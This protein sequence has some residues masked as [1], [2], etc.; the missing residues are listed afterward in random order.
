MYAKTVI[1]LA[2]MLA[3]LSLAVTGCGTST[4]SKF[5]L[6]NSV[7]GPVKDSH[8][9]EKKSTVT[10]GVGPVEFPAYLDRQQIVTRI[11]ENEVDLAMF[12]EW[13]EPLKENFIRVLVENLA[14]LDTGDLFAVY[15]MRGSSPVDFQLEIEVLRLDGSLGGEVLLIARWTVFGGGTNQMLLTRKSTIKEASG[16]ADYRSLVAAQSR[17]VEALSREIAIAMNDLSK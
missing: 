5:Y 2:T 3:F 8:M 7:S 15:P 1:N 11:N 6:L 9:T 13:A 10:I 17:A 14:A 4:P 12:H 16:S